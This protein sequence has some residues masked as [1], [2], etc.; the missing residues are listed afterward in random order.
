MRNNLIIL[1]FLICFQSFSQVVV[2]N[3]G[4][5]KIFVAIGFYENSAWTTKGWFPIEPHQEQN[6]H[7]PKLFGGNKFYYCAVIDKCD[8]G[9]YGST[10]L[11]VNKQDGFTLV[12]ADSNSN[13]NNPNLSTVKFIEVTTKPLEKT[14]IDITYS[15]LVCFNKKEG[16]WKLGLDKEGNFAEVEDDIK[17]YREINFE[18]NIP[19]GW[20]K[21]YYLNGKLK[22]EFKISSFEP[23]KYDG[24]CT[25]YLENGNIEREVFYK[26]G[27]ST[28]E[29]ILKENGLTL[30]R[31]ASY[32]VIKLPIQKLFLNSTSNAYWK[33]GNSKSIIPV[34]LPEGT[35]EWY[36]E[37][38]S[39]RNEESVKANSQSFQ[40]ASE[41]TSLIDASGL[42]SIS[43]G[44][45]STPPGE[46]ICDIYLIENS[47]YN[48]FLNDQQFRHYP[49]GTR[50][51]FKSGVVQ[52]KDLSLKNPMI[53][54]QNNDLSYGINVNIQI[55]AVVSKL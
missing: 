48:Q 15:N 35:V 45:F 25:W 16:K 41:L 18:N 12:N 17:F 7:N 29:K 39:S 19:K 43:V 31:Q 50:Q 14:Q 27:V 49:I 3:T 46:D 11:F 26:N 44:M 32:E 21:D 40:L 20:C 38:S 2:K 55:V 30:S 23:L 54:V 37:F 36:Y 1:I 24:N 8:L 53:A 22:A 52:I 28:S 33:G 5:K 47:S 13:Y 42:L 9:V 51:N 6:V 4:S 10:N 34:I